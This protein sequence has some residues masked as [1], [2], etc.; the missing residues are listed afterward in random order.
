MAFAALG[1]PLAAQAQET[2]GPAP[3]VT[4]LNAEDV[5][6]AFEKNIPDLAKVYLSSTPED[7]ADG[8][9]VGVL[10]VGGGDK[11]PILKFA[12]EIAAGQHGEVDS[13]LLFYRGKLLFESYDRRGRINYPH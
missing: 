8:I 10:G 3:E 7:R 9:P 2:S 6:Y 12:N 13:P 1:G 11:E 4:D 5:S